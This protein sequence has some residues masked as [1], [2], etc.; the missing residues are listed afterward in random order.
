MVKAVTGSNKWSL[1]SIPF[2]VFDFNVMFHLIHVASVGSDQFLSF[3][4]IPS[5]DR[6]LYE[7]KFR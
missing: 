3:L 7:P 5:N 2:V 6:S 4:K 1:C